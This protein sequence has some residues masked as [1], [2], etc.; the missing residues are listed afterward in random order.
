MLHSNLQSHTPRPQPK[1]SNL[2]PQHSNHLAFS[3]SGCSP[4]HRDLSLPRAERTEEPQADQTPRPNAKRV[5]E[6]TGSNEREVDVPGPAAVRYMPCCAVLTASST[7]PSTKRAA[8]SAGAASSSSC[9]PPFEE[10]EDA[11]SRAARADAP[12]GDA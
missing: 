1:T 10:A 8:I 7:S 4:L 12:A 9:R 5:F 3:D 2:H 11:D 6:Q